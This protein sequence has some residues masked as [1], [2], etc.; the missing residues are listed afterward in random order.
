MFW[1]R[2]V[3]CWLHRLR[4]LLW[5]HL[6]S[7]VVTQQLVTV[8]KTKKAIMQESSSFTRRGRWFHLRLT[9]DRI[10]NRNAPFV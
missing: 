7:G 1:L 10:L 2:V 3:R 5:R 4:G 9:S 8:V 6:A